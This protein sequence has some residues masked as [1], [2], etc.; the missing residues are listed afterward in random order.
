MKALL[1]L[2][3]LLS[4]LPSDA[5]ITSAEDRIRRESNNGRDSITVDEAIATKIDIGQRTFLLS[6][7]V[8]TFGNL[9]QIE[10]NRWRISLAEGGD[11]KGELHLP[12]AGVG[13]LGKLK[14]GDV[15]I[16]RIKQDEGLFTLEVLGVSEVNVWE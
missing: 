7:D 10:T 11:Y 4:P 3:I 6:L 16:A 15:V 8:S 14:K 5:Q 1:A 13:I 2:L 9:E 12:R